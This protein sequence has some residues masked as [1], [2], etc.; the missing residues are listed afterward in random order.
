[1][2]FS[3]SIASDYD[4]AELRDVGQFG[5]DDSTVANALRNPTTV[6]LAAIETRAT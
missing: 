5:A 4:E 2:S 3:I 6:A 1:V